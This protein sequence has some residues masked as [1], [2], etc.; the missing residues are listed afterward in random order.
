MGFSQRF[1]ATWTQG[2]L[3]PLAKQADVIGDVAPSLSKS[4][5][6]LTSDFLVAYACDDATLVG[7]LM[8][9]T[10]DLTVRTNRAGT[11]EVQQ[12]T[13]TGT[14]TGGT[15]TLTFDG[16]TTG[17]IA[18][19]ASAADVRTALILLPNIAD[20]D[21]AAGTG[22]PLPGTPVNINFAAGLGRRD[23]D[24]ITADDSGLTG[25]STPTATVTT[26]TPGVAPDDT[27][28]LVAGEPTVFWWEG[29]HHDKPLSAAIASLY[30]TNATA[31]AAV[32]EIRALHA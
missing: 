13:I 16:Q 14:P 20:A 25:G 3:A 15:F 24:L 29:A 30:V 28:E 5:P 1:K 8:T 17:P 22:G 26:T 12:L 31:F 21:L 23:V 7:F 2:G 19:N 11:N 27:F 10:K 32:L 9:S 6:G 4:I 18:Y